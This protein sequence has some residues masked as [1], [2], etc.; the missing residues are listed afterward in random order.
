MELRD[1]I[2]LARGF[3]K[4]AGETINESSINE[5]SISDQSIDQ[6]VLNLAEKGIIIN[7]KYSEKEI[8]YQIDAGLIFGKEGASIIPRVSIVPLGTQFPDGLN[9]SSQAYCLRDGNGLELELLGYNNVT[10]RPPR[11]MIGGTIYGDVGIIC[12]LLIAKETVD[13]TI[14]QK[15]R[16]SLK[17]TYNFALNFQDLLNLLIPRHNPKSE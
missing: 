1:K 3:S 17:K 16:E 14:S 4:S 9:I 13:P 11:D 5:S 6:L 12:N 7:P 15:V 8:T 10:S 2:I